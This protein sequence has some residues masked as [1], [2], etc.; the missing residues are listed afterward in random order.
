[1]ARFEV[2]DQVCSTPEVLG[3]VMAEIERRRTFSE[4]LTQVLV[5]LLA[6]MHTQQL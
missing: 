2:L 5:L 3:R 1:M 4:A 6:K